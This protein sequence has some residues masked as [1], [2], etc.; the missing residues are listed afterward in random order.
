M[1][2]AS[3]FSRGIHGL[4]VELL[5]HI[6]TFTDPSDLCMLRLTCRAMYQS[7][8]RHFAKTCVHTLKTDLS[9]TSLARI[10]EAANDE[11]FRPYIRNLQIV[12]NSKA[13][14]EELPPRTTNEVHIQA[15]CNVLKRLVNCQSVELHYS[16]YTTTYS[17]GDGITLDETT[18]LVLKAIATEHIPKEFFS[19]EIMK[20]RD[21]HLKDSLPQFP[22]TTLD[23][24]AFSHLKELTLA[25]PDANTETINWMAK[26]IQGAKS[27]KKLAIIFNWACKSTS[28]LSQISSVGCLPELQE[29]T[30]SRMTFGSSAA[31]GIFLYNIRDSVRS[32][33]FSTVQVEIG[34][35]RS[36][37]RELGGGMY[38][39]DSLTLHRV[40]ESEEF[41]SFRRI[42]EY[43]LAEQSLDKR[44]YR[45]FSLCLFG[46]GD[47]SFSYSGPRFN[48]VMQKVVAL[49]ELS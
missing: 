17:G 18:G 23:I 4:P 7:S 25:I 26:M 29:V 19:L 15:W 37:L 28:L 8:L 24:P 11:A 3:H 42:P 46:R 36:I 34:G 30:F 48:Q 44:L 22:L 14:T 13:S 12:G 5:A 21:R 31:L 35:W 38:Q 20:Y 9:P 27:L 45:P 33:T 1:S 47:V 6:A 32:L 2:P 39:L 16:A 10:E 40:M 41:L 43:A 49:A